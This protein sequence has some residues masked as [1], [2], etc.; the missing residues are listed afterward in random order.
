MFSQE[1][2]FSKTQL[3][4]PTFQP[5][6]KAP[7]SIKRC[8]FWCFPLKPQF[9]WSF[10]V[11]TVMVPKHFWPRQIMCMKIP[12]KNS[13]RQFLIKK[14]PFSLHFSLFWMT[15]LKTHFLKVFWPFS[16]LFFCFSCSNI[17]KTKQKM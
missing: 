6:Q 3:V 10:P 4:K 5:S 17:K 1:H 9:L 15:T 7:V 2:S 11:F 8:H 14:N 13:V 16:I 12:D